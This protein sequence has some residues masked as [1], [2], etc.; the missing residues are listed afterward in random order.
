MKEQPKKAATPPTEKN[1]VEQLKEQIKKLESQLHQQPQSL[2]EKIKF[3]Q[4][5]Q[6]MIKRLS[7]LDTYATGLLKIGEEMQK[8]TG[9]DDFLT[10]RY[11]LKI[12]HRPTSY[13]SEQEVLKIANP[14]LISEVLGYSI[15]KINEKRTEL[16]TLINA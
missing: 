8:D 1:E 12:T 4:Q 5:K 7:L 2:E 9:D 13:G 15:G 10:E 3:F 6:E 16:Q 11:F 14:K